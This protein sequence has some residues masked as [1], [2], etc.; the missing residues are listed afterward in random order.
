MGPEAMDIT[1]RALITTKEAGV[2]IG[3]EG[4]SVAGIRSTT[5][6]KMGV[7]KVIPKIHERILTVQGPLPNV[8]K[9]LALLASNLIQS[10]IQHVS[11]SHQQQQQAQGQDEQDQPSAP[12]LADEESPFCIIRLLVSHQLVGSIIGKSGSK[13]K[14]IQEE[15]SS[16]IVVSKDT[17]PEST[18]RIVEIYGVVDSIHLAV[19][20]I[21]KALLRDFSMDPSSPQQQHHHH[22]HQQQNVMLYDPLSGGSMGVIRDYTRIAADGSLTSPRSPLAYGH[23]QAHHAQAM[24]HHHHHHQQQQQQQQQQRMG[25]YVTGGYGMYPPRS[26]PRPSSSRYSGS[27]QRPYYPSSPSTTE[28]HPDLDGDLDVQQPQTHHHDLMMDAVTKHLDVPADLVGCLI[29]RGG[30][31]ISHLRRSSGARLHVSE[32]PT[33]DPASGLGSDVAQRTVTMTG[34][35][36]AVSRALDMIYKQLE[37]EK[38]RRRVRKEREESLL[39]CQE[40]RTLDS[41]PLGEQE[42][43]K[44]STLADTT[45]NLAQLAM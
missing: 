32:L 41:D 10:Q 28:Q 30:A 38:E 12:S 36:K 25:G 2:I 24:A 11:S 43:D 26:S 21:G 39:S 40:K 6:V 27:N 34:P 19:Y 14:E 1:L 23:H 5:G 44:E 9:A 8:S 13:I 7:S 33:T 3:K 42:E 35:D 4:K 20:H 15:S 18:E 17:L 37:L 29:G 31:F 45:E 16:K 22:Q